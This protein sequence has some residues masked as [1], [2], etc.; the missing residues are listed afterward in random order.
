[1]EWQSRLLE[2]LIYERVRLHVDL[3]DL[4]DFERDLCQSI[5]R[6]LRA[7][8]THPS[9]EDALARRYVQKAWHRLEEEWARERARESMDCPLCE[10]P[11]ECPDRS[12]PSPSTSPDG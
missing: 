4:I 7:S 9:E 6:A 3:V 5:T 12:F 8:G 10:A 1:M 11:I 2:E